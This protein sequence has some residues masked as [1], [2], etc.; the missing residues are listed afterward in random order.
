MT[1]FNTIT[2]LLVLTAGFAYLNTRFLRLPDTIGLMIISLLFSVLIIIGSL[3]APHVFDPIQQVINQIDYTTVVLDVMLSSLLFAG[4]FHT[5]LNMLSRV[6]QSI[7]LYAV[8]GVLLST[9]LI[10]GM[11]YGLLVV[12]AMPL[13]FLYCLLFGALI[14]P[15]DPIAVLGILTRANV[16]KAIEIKIVGESLFND[17]IGVVVFLTLL[18]VVRRGFDSVTPGEIANLFAQEA[19]GGIIFGLLL[20]LCLFYL[21]RSIDHYQTEVML[22]VAGVLGGY[23]VASYLHVSGPLAMVVAG[24]FTGNRAKG[25]AMSLVT[26]EYVGRFWELVD[27]ILNAL[28]FVLIGFRLITLDY[29][30]SFAVVGAGA[31]GIS[32]LARYLSIGLPMWLTRSWLFPGRKDARMMT[33]GGLRG[34]LSIAM[35]LSIPESV[36]AKNLLV[37]ATYTVVLFSIVVQGLT[38]EKVARRLYGRFR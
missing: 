13:D 1:L 2:L 9:G 25:V 22:T 28:L 8:V 18:E 35:A 14:S 10:A 26:E 38:L 23:S 4:A 15:T 36:A 37:F 19:I 34:G 32:L 31:I 6:W 11:L 16:P 21:L 33:W 29:S 3:I 27:V 12:L 5:D 7:T 17:G 30:F 24:L 20:G